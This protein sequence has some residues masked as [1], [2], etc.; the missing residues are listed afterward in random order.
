MYFRMQCLSKHF[1]HHSL[2]PLGKCNI[3][4][5][6]VTPKDFQIC[7]RRTALTSIQLITR[8]GP[9]FNNDSIVQKSRT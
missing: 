5:I 9:Q 2:P 3:S 1:V 8:S 4:E 6:V 7:G